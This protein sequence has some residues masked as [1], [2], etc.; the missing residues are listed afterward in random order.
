MSPVLTVRYDYKSIDIPQ[1]EDI[2][3]SDIPL[4]AIFGSTSSTFGSATFGASNDPMVRTTLTGSGHT[5][6][7][8][9]RTDDKNRS[10]GIN[11]FYLDYMPSGRR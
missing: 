2:T 3:L 8:R 5:V 10:Y 1:P 11:G 7:I 4:P 6:S 9:I